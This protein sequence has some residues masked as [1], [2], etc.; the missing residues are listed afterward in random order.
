MHKAAVKIAEM[1]LMT[2]QVTKLTGHQKLLLVM[3]K[4]FDEVCR[5]HNI[6]YQ[7][8]AGT[9]LGAARHHGFIPW[10]DD[11]D[12]ILMRDEYE[13]FF[14]EASGDFNPEIYYVQQEHGAHWPMPFSKLRRNNTTCIEK[15]HPRDSRMHQGVYIDIFPCDIL[16]DR[17]IMR[18]LQFAASKVVLAKALYARGYE[19]DSVAKK[20][21]MQISR[22]FPDRPL[23]S[24]CMCKGSTGSEMVQ[25]FLAGGRKFEKN[26]LPKAWMEDTEKIMFEDAMFPI[27]AHYDALLTQLYGDWH[28][29]PKPEERRCKEHAAILDLERSYTEHLDEQAAMQ[30]KDYTRSIR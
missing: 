20:V 2:T 12:V 5:K 6:E 17:Q 14:K 22:L 23:E 28:T 11:V 4:D 8:F 21:F 15:Y 16:S 19:T 13:R 18:K 7:L 27:S 10:D 9:A 3:L 30:I 29:L 25:T 24:I 1:R 26:M